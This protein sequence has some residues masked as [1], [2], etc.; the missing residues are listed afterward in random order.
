MSTFASGAV[1]ILFSGGDSPGM[2]A[3]LRAIT[4]FG[5]NIHK[6]SVIGVR[7][8]YK[9]LVRAVETVASRP[10]GIQALESEMTGH[11]G[12]AGLINSG[13]HLIL[14][15]HAAVSGIVGQGGILLGSA[16]CPEFVNAPVRAAVIGL[17]DALGVKALIV[18]GGD[19]SLAG[20][21]A[22]AE[23]SALQV[24]GIPGTIDNDLRYTEMALGVD[25]ALGTLVWAV[26]HFKDTA[27]SHRRVMVLETMGR[28]SGELAIRSAISAGAEIVLTPEQGSLTAERI[29][30]LAAGLETSMTHG[31]THAIVLVA[32]GVKFHP[33]QTRNRAYVL[34]DEFRKY[35]EREG[36]AFPE[37][38]IRP[39][40]LGHLQRGG[41]ASPF[42]TLLAARFADCAWTA[43]ASGKKSGV[44][45]LR[46]SLVELVPFDTPAVPGRTAREAE[47][48]RLHRA[49]SQW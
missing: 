30:E 8:G 44:T 14:L 1:A 26:Q 49:L 11:I 37:L 4:R 23:E 45:V 3:C 5:L 29:R 34:A 43:I 2:N 48:H 21:K 32:E 27:R 33:P 47:F 22:V 20:A 35:F 17:L 28:E 36:S 18:C 10:D 39:S 25:T 41:D 7:Y 6:R 40:V 9:G 42:D 19:G 12:R 16:R 31:R 46:H 15:D 13:Q 24:I 38:E